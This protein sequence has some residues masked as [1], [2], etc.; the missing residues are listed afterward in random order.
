[1]STPIYFVVT[2]D[3][4]PDPVSNPQDDA[5]VMAK[6][7][8]MRDILVRHA[9]G[10]G[11]FS[12][13][14]SPVFRDRFFAAP[15]LAFWQSWREGGGELVLH[16]EEDLYRLPGSPPSDRSPYEDTAHMAALIAE[17]VEALRRADL[18]FAGYR[19]GY[20]GFT[21]GIGQALRKAG[22]F[23][24]LSCAPGIAF[25]NKAAAWAKA[26]LSAYYMS[27]GSCETPA[28]PGEDSPLFEIP[29]GWD[30]Q[31]YEFTGRFKM[32]EHYLAN[33]F[34]TLEA[35]SGVWD[36]IVAR[37]ADAAKPPIVS[38]ICHTYAMADEPVRERLAGILRYMRAHRGVAVNPTRA[39]QIFDGAR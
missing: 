2:V 4:D 21:L 11:A 29:F 39:K 1:M 15:F 32:N 12:V 10:T 6:Y 38:L 24:D 23:I 27:N 9:D 7:A 16:P 18:A 31:P 13:H 25:P 33:E 20:H 35:M 28:R 19:G 26:P 37:S 8:I 22:I 17:K 3:S 30:T 34:S 14:T 36:K 5:A